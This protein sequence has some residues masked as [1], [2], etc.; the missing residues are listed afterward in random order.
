M[1]PHQPHHGPRR[2][3]EIELPAAL[4]RKRRG[5]HGRRRVLLGVR[6]Q[7]GRF[8]VVSRKWWKFE[9]GVISG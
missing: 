4:I 8:Q 5:S 2:G 9:G 3:R 6:L 7:R 1:N